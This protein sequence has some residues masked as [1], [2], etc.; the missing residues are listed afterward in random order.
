MELIKVRSVEALPSN[1]I[2]ILPGKLKS[3]V[4][5]NHNF[6]FRSHSVRKMLDFLRLAALSSGPAVA[7]AGRV[8]LLGIWCGIDS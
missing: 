5:I 4:G 3:N 7:T 1:R 6:S 8:E 2:C